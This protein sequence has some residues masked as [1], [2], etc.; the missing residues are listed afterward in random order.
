MMTEEQK[1][2]KS[3]VLLDTYDRVFDIF[4]LNND[5]YFKRTQI[6]MFAI[7]AAL[8]AGFIKLAWDTQIETIISSA[9]LNIVKFILFVF[10]PLFGS[11]SAFTWV[12]LITKQW[13]V[14][15]LYRCYL[16]YIE[17]NLLEL[18]IPLACFRA[19]SLVFKYKHYIEF[20]GSKKDNDPE[21]PTIF[22]HNGR[23]VELSLMT[24]EERTAIFLFAFWMSCIVTLLTY[25]INVQWI[26]IDLPCWLYLLVFSV[27]LLG[28]FGLYRVIQKRLDKKERQKDKTVKFEALT[29]IEKF[30]KV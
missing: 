23:K 26:K 6:L 13:N 28:A 1:D 19:E 12:E 5:N 18:Q 30:K 21:I 8:F 11:I 2:K 27:V 22:P 10:I 7:Q 17:R 4:Q 9:S 20:E 25:T 24:I 16:R 14:L 15:E 3:K 29:N